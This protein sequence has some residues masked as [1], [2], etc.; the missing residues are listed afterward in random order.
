[1]RDVVVRPVEPGDVLQLYRNM[2][3]ADIDEVKAS[4]GESVLVAIADSVAVSSLCWAVDI[5][6]SLCCMFGCAPIGGLLSRSAAPWMLATDVLDK[7][8]LALM[9]TCRGYLSHM[10]STY[11]HLL[12]YVDARNVK[13]VRWL[14]R[15]GFTILPAEPHGPLGMP[16]HKF[17][18]R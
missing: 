6:D 1:V 7:H 10:Y 11:P 18:M 12:N 17:E 4:G 13:S 16:F 2:R 8:P 3:Q 15:I 5:D 14:R 9:K